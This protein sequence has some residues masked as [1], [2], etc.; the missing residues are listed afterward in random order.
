MKSIGFNN[1]FLPPIRCGAKTQTRRPVDE[2]LL[3]AMDGRCL[4]GEEDAW[5]PY[6]RVGDRLCV[7]GTDIVI[8]LVGVRLERVQDISEVDAVAEGVH[9]TIAGDQSGK[10]W[11][12]LALVNFG[13]VWDSIYSALGLGWDVNPRVWALT[14]KCVEGGA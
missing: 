14:F 11:G 6:G 12:P 2:A 5:C 8:E 4:A 3:R 9:A 7:P 13:R 1:E 10:P